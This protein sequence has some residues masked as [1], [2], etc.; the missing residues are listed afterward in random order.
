M[1]RSSVGISPADGVH[2]RQEQHLRA[3]GAWWVVQARACGVWPVALAGRDGVIRPS[4]HALGS[5]SV[6][7]TYWELIYRA[8]K[9]EDWICKRHN[10]KWQVKDKGF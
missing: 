5:I 9:H 3:G 6:S 8:W 7:G 4:G 10:V 1:W 2:L